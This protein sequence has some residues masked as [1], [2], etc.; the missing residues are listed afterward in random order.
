MRAELIDITDPRWGQLLERTPHD[1]YHTCDYLRFAAAHEQGEPLGFLAEDERGVLLIPLLA[2]DLPHRLGADK[3]W[4]DLTSPYGYASPLYLPKEPGASIGT[5]LQAF[6]QVADQHHFVAAFL[7]LHPL[8]PLPLD[9]SPQPFCLVRHG[10]TVTIDLRLDD[11]AAWRQMRENHRKGIK[12]LNARGFS[13]VMDDVAYWDGFARAY[14]ETM[15]RVGA[16]PFYFFSD[17]YFN[18]LKQE[19]GENVHLCTV[20][21][22]SLELAAAGVFFTS[23]EIVEFHLSGTAEAYVRMAPTKLMFEFV[24]DWARRAGYVSL[25]IGGGV[26]GACDSL[27]N[28]KVGFSKKLHDF[29]TLRGVVNEERYGETARLA[30]CVESMTAMHGYFPAYRAV[31]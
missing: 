11:E 7:R 17:A 26:G 18:D 29:Y 22:P 19:H 13:V 12:R 28:F 30:G 27:F 4:R 9:H 6:L 5:Y 23:G 1:Y 25:H 24:R 21:S 2:R 3:R 20:L 31:S 14:R 15:Q 8:L 10:S 16:A